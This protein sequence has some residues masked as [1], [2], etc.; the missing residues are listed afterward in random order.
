MSSDFMITYTK[1]IYT[2]AKMVN[3]I[4]VTQVEDNRGDEIESTQFNELMNS[5]HSQ[6]ELELLLKNQSDSSSDIK[7]SIENEKNLPGLF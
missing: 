1:S 6:K 3:T 2:K 4:E 7:S 5:L